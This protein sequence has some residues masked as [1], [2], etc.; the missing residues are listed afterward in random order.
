LL[1]KRKERWAYLSEEAQPENGDVGDWRRNLKAIGTY[2]DI[3]DQQ[4]F[5]TA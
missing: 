2:R 4:A 5:I 3:S 1:L